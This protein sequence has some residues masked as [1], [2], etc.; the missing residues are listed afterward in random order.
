MI[1]CPNSNIDSV[2]GCYNGVLPAPK[3]IE[4]IHY[5][6]NSKLMYL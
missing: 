4:I 3:N 2:G 5:L 1:I 6:E